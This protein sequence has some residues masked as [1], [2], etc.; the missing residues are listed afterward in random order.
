MTVAPTL[1]TE[2]LILRPHRV[3]DFE[4]MTPLFGSDWARYMDGPVSAAELWRWVGAEVGSWSLLGYG[5]WA[6]DLRDSNTFIGQVGINK[7]ANFPE[8]ELGWCVWPDFEGQGFAQEAALA[9]RHW[10]FAQLKLD[11]LVS[12][13]DPENARSIALAT[14]LGATLDDQAAGPDATDLV[15]RHPAPEERP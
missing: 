9:A 3:E 2:R 11:T 13:I 15:Y 10:G 7:P 14:R 4:V 5:S 12:Y 8:V 6:V 1:F